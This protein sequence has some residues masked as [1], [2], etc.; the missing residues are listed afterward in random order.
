MGGPAAAPSS[1]GTPSVDL[2]R[3]V[4]AGLGP[5]GRD[6]VFED[7]CDD[8]FQVGSAL[9]IDKRASAFDDEFSQAAL[10]KR[11]ELETAAEL[12]DNLITLERFD[13]RPNRLYE[14]R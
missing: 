7:L 5:V 9:A 14:V 8:Q 10:D 6:L 3:W 12:V 1:A 2:L 11:G 4:V 13:H